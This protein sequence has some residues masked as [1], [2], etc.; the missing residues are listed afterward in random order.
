MT[1]EEAVRRTIAGY[2][3]L[4]DDGRFDEWATLYTEDA[5]FHVMGRTYEGREAIKRFIEKGQ[6]PER[7]GK[8]ICFNSVIDVA[9]D[10]AGAVTDYIFIDQAKTIVSAGRYHDVLVRQPDRWRF[11]ERRIVFMGDEAS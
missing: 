8:H 2:A 3:H 9:G 4:C 5:H 10:R 7:R 6:P 11:A 1:D